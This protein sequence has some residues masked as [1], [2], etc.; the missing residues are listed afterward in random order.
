MRSP[1]F[2]TLKK[3]SGLTV[4]EN[5]VFCTDR[6]RRLVIVPAGSKDR[7]ALMIRVKN[8][9]NSNHEEDKGIAILPDMGN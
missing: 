1:A 3:R 8:S 6:L 5:A 7:S 4:T 2:I 9:K